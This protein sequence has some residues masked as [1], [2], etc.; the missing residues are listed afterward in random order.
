ME[1]QP[2]V[3]I[4]DDDPVMR[5]MLA[6]QFQRHFSLTPVEASNNTEA[7]QQAHTQHPCLMTTDMY[8]SGGTGLRL[9]KEIRADPELSAIPIVLIS[10]SATSEERQ[11]ARQAGVSAVF[12]KPFDRQELLSSIAAIL[13]SADTAGR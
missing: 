4:V 2:V 9:I 6:R 11:Q 13:A 10:G 1:A 8:R 3:L 12:G 7:L 5:Q